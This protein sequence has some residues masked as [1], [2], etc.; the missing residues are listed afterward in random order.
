M[1][2]YAAPLHPGPSLARWRLTTAA[3]RP[4]PGKFRFDF[5][6]RSHFV[7]GH[8]LISCLVMSGFIFLIE[9]A[10]RKFRSALKAFRPDLA[11]KKQAATGM[12]PY[13]CTGRGSEQAQ[14]PWISKGFCQGQGRQTT[15]NAACTSVPNQI[16]AGTI[17]II[18][19][20]TVIVP[21]PPPLSVL[22]HRANPSVLAPTPY[23][24]CGLNVRCGPGGV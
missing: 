23:L 6:G 2:G 9:W 5:P 10:N 22:H 3:T 19:T 12:K 11:G 16:P 4:K 21:T 8:C 7:K 13:P 14:C 17:V 24:A 20:T 18:H 1:G 15:R